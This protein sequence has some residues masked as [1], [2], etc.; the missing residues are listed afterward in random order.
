M[1]R[2]VKVTVLLFI[3]SSA[4][5]AGLY[6]GSEQILQ[7]RY[8]LRNQ[9]RTVTSTAQIDSVFATL[10]KV[11]F[12][13]IPVSVLN[14]NHSN[15][16]QYKNKLAKKT[17][18]ELSREDL[19][20][21]V[22]ADYRLKHFITK[23]YGYVKTYNKRNSY[24]TCI[25]RRVLH[26]FLELLNELEK[27]DYDPSAIKLRS[28]HRHPKRNYYIGGASQSRHIYGEAIDIGV[29]DINKDGK[30]NDTD[31]QIVLDLLDQ[32]IIGNQGGIG[33]YPGT[34]AVHFDVRGRRAR[35]NSYTP[36]IRKKNQGR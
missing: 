29:R 27:L 22:V 15:K 25:D 1:K 2:I 6:F 35:W 5:A 33:L 34:K 30:S 16:P 26:K 12:S 10:S 36:A 13:D 17:F 31:K 4:L 24:Y 8:D 3:V 20:K 11:K 28:G 18:Y 32:K 14:E 7:I 9:N 19:F 21:K 23:D